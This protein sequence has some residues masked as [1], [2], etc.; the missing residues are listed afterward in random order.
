[1]APFEALY[2]QRCRTPLN[3]SGLGERF[4]FGPDLVKEAEEKVKLIEYSL[5]VAQHRHQRY[6]DKR[7]QPL[8]FQIGD[9]VYLKVSPMK[10]VNRF[11]I[12]APFGSLELNS[13]LIIVI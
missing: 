3:W 9:F 2:G 4:F 13:V 1:M 6:A 10:G 11:G 12:N 8:F 5:K 7:R